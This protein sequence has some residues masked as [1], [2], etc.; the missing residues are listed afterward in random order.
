MSTPPGQ[1]LQVALSAH[2]AHFEPRPGQA[3]MIGAVQ[4]ALREGHDLVVEAG[5]GTGKT[6]AYLLPILA[7][8]RRAIL[9]TA[10]KQLQ[11][12]LLQHDLPVAIAATGARIEAAVLKGRANYL[13][14]HRLALRRGSLEQTMGRQLHAVVEASLRSET[15]DV[16]DVHDVDERD[17]I[18][19]H[20][21]SSGENCLGGECPEH[22]HCFVVRA[23]RRALVADLVI[24]NH[25]VLLAD[26]ALRDRW[27][28]ATMLGGADTIVVDEA[29]ALAD[30]VS[31]FF[32]V[33]VSSHQTRALAGDLTD[34]AAELGGHKGAAVGAAADR[35]ARASSELWQGV[36]GG[37]AQQ[38]FDDGLLGRLVG[39]RD[40][41]LDVL[42][43]QWR[44]L[45]APELVAASPAVQKLREVIEGLEHDLC[46]TIDHTPD[47]G[48]M[49]RWVERRA[50]SVA[51]IAR[52]AECGPI[53][54]RTLLA[55]PAQR[56]F[57]SATLAV[58][59]DFSAFLHRTGLPEHTPRLCLPGGFDYQQQALLYVPR[60]VPEP[61]ATGREIA[62]AKEIARL[63][64]AS[65]GGTFALFTSRRAMQDAFDRAAPDLPM[66]ALL[67]GTESKAALLRRFVDEQPAVLF[68]TMGFWQGVDLPGDV[69]RLVV[70]D[71]I[72]FPPPDDP[73]LAA[74]GRRLEQA[75][76][77][78]FAALSIPAA[79]IHLRQ[80]FGRLIRSATDRGV[81][82]ILDPRLSRRSYGKRL[83]HAL[84]DAPRTVSFA[85]VQAFF[86]RR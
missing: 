70:L 61:W 52:P 31:H 49:V 38:P 67:Q 76:K 81:V 45:G 28:G 19:P 54:Q 15:G 2:L 48:P 83:L 65:A 85:D 3:E 57:T 73:L 72:P 71:K 21:T 35:I 14:L 17:P 43:D 47:D 62:L 75:G 77:S 86:E 30:T 50:R 34:L 37:P 59:A 42:R 55:E 68:A 27:E 82:A 64:R 51:I 24:V 44:L 79:A 16:A 11:N 6:L 1:H 53:L 5:T 58:G 9:S 8:G 32:G 7:S 20:V 29:H 60:H 84:P 10:T 56:I 23:R 63:A 41:L 26:Y 39:P 13:C 22:D 18:W 4:G 74:R 12:Q 36:G 40:E 25:H 33:T 66:T 78:S 80:G 69:L 46:T